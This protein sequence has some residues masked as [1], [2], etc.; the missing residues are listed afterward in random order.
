MT[1]EIRYREIPYNYTSLSDREI[2]LRYFDQETLGLIEALRAQRITGRSARLIAETVGDIFIIDRNPYVQEDFLAEDGALRRLQRIHEQ[3]LKTTEAAARGNPE[4]LKLLAKVRQCDEAFFERIA[5]TKRIRTRM[6]LALRGA[7]ARK[8]ISYLPFD[9]V[10]HSTDA[11]DWRVEHP[12]AV[13]FPDS[14]EELPAIIAAARKLGLSLIARGGGTGLT[15][16]AVP[17]NRRTVAVNMEKLNRIHGVTSCTVAGRSLPVVT[18][19]A[20]AV[21]EDVIEYCRRAGHIFATD[22]TSAWASTIGG[23]IAENAGGKKCVQWGTAIDNLLSWQIVNANGETLEIRRRAHPHRKILPDDRVI[24]DVHRV[25]HAGESFVRAIELSGTDIRKRGLGKDI[26]NKAL[27][28]LPG[29]Q[30]EGGDGIITRAQFVLYK[31]FAHCRTLC[32]EFFGKKMTSVADAIVTI[33]H[34]YDGRGPA[35]LTALEHFDIRYVRAINYRNKSSRTEI[36]Q[37]VLLVDVEGDDV[38]AVEAAAANIAASVQGDDTEAVVA[39][40]SADRAAFW[41][42]RKNLGAIAKHTNAFK[43]NEDIVIPLD[44]LPAFSEFVERINTLKELSNCESMAGRLADHLKGIAPPDHDEA[45]HSRL[46][47]SA[48]ILDRIPTRI[49]HLRSQIASGIGAPPPRHV[50][51][52][53]AQR[54]LP[55]PGKPFTAGTDILAPLRAQLHGY[56]ELTAVIEQIAEEERRRQIIIA[57]HMH[58]GDGNIHVNIPVHSSDYAMM[59]EASDTAALAMREAVRL[60]GVVSGE[61]GIGLT[62]LQFLDD[63]ILHEYA[64]YK[65]V[66]DPE[67]IFNPGKLQRRFPEHLIYTPSFSLLELEAYI[68]E[69]TDLKELS[70]KIATCVRC[71]KCKSVCCTNIPKEGM[72]FNPR[73]KILAVGQITEAVLYHAQT[74]DM[75]SFRH[76][77][78][79]KDISDHCTA[80]HKCV[81]PCPVKIDFGNVTLAMRELQ[82]RRIRAPRNSFVRLALYYLSKRGYLANALLRR[83]ALGPAC[84]LQR[85]GHKLYVAGLGR[86]L[87][88]SAPRT[89]ALLEGRISARGQSSLREYLGLRNRDS[90]YSMRDKSQPILTSVVYFPGC[91]SE[92]LYPEISMATLAM[93]YHTRVRTFLPPSFTCCGYPFQA[94]GQFERAQLRS[95]ENRIV[96]HRMADCIGSSEIDAILVS[97]GT[98]YEMLEKYDLRKVFRNAPLLDINEFLVKKG[99]RPRSLG[100][101]REILYHE[102][103]HTPLKSLGFDSTIKALL[104]T[105]PAVVPECC[106]DAGTLALSRPDISCVLRRRKTNELDRRADSKPLEILTTCP[107][108]VAG[109]SKL[110]NDQPV[111][112]KSLIVKVAE[113]TLGLDWERNFIRTMRQ[114]AIERMPF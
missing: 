9:R 44:A 17:V 34:A 62:K 114:G 101:E 70:E 64:A 58:A 85:V 112:G 3:R 91:G 88:A 59:R 98:C 53:R 103:C 27:K 78:K 29:L 49:A 42:D 68:L 96:F 76:F 90:L 77:Q 21:T 33:R 93:L 82:A 39:V 106:G 28:G 61:H 48:R 84:T 56:E 12:F 69:A 80:C 45:L 86:A 113:E 108:C 5:E 14:A 55:G 97:C 46:E 2:I 57:T 95:F 30:K 10:A 63:D 11:T 72:L 102:P 109:L 99:F 79:L 66:A 60:G 94:N 36:P 32:I 73:N 111:A 50:K 8:N 19:D 38:R 7:T 47:K 105:H 13:L 4:A 1:P 65:Q 110:K 104:A 92:R 54:P 16:G 18:V 22:P 20:G 26:T 67:C 25:A 52:S 75:R 100:S 35:F 81:A 107:S 71:G 31:P 40:E 15:A 37:G 43:L 24:F 89:H 83:F 51:A 41:K 6:L 23:N 74:M 87:R